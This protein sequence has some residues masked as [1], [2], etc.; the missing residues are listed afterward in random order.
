MKGEIQYWNELANLLDAADKETKAPFV[1]STLQILQEHHPIEA[2]TFRDFTEQIVA[3]MKEA[4]W[5]KK[6]MNSIDKPINILLKGEWKEIAGITP[7]LMELFRG[8]YEKSNFYKEARIVSF[9]DHMY[10]FILNKMK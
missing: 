9:I 7:S 5:N 4:K 6:Y 8:I 2:K 1:E 3:G 10:Q